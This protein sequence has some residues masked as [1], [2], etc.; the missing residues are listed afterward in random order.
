MFNSKIVGASLHD[1]N[2]QRFNQSITEYVIC[3]QN[4]H[5]ES[6]CGV[7]VQSFE[8]GLAGRYGNPPRGGQRQTWGEGTGTGGHAVPN[9]PSTQHAG[10]MYVRF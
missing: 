1:F 5:I 2:Y 8:F 6:F 4:L 7:S 9:T 10:V 3:G